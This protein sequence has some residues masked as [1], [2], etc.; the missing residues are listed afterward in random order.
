MVVVCIKNVYHNVN[1]TINKS[2]TVIDETDGLGLI[3]TPS[4]HYTV[5]DDIGKIVWY[6]S[7]I[8][9]T[10]DEFRSRQIDKIL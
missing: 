4:D 2:Y 5:V 8:F 6:G 3:W 1:L 7:E 10:L 9:I